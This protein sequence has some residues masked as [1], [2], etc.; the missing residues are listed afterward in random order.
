[1][2]LAA[3]APD[4]ALTPERRNALLRRLRARIREFDSDAL[5]DLLA[6][7]GYALDQVALRSH[8]TRAPQPSLFQA[9]HLADAAA[10]ADEA[11]GAVAAAVV[12]ANIG[13]ASCRSPLPS[14][15]LGLLDDYR[16]HEPLGALIDVLDHGLVRD[17]LLALAP[18]RVFDA[19]DTATADLLRLNALATPSGLTWLFRHSFPEL[20]VRVQRA[21]GERALAASAARVGHATLGASTFGSVAAVS[22]ADLE[23][24]L[25]CEESLSPAGAA[26][27]HEAPRRLRSQVFPALDAARVHLTVALLMLEQRS[28]ARIERDSFTGHDP[29][30]GGADV[31]RR[32][33]IFRGP[34]PSAPP[35][36]PATADA[37]R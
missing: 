6:H 30:P 27:I 26:W 11:D 17:R 36:A 33:E 28:V 1:M 15:I 29:L 7:L 18:E 35:A 3:I 13:L 12:D 31:A 21:P 22:V 20:G 37:A 19:W 14:Y 34:L 16:F 9:L 23:V 4:P 25:V 32:V 5:F 8:R 24:T 2:R 10:G